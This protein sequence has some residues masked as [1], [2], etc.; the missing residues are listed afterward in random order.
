[1]RFSLKTALVNHLF[2]FYNGGANKTY[3]INAKETDGAMKFR[4]SVTFYLLENDEVII[5]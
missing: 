5:P 3:Q 4:D 1:M 2:R